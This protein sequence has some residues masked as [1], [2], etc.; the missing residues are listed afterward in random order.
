MQKQITLEQIVERDTSLLANLASV[1]VEDVKAVRTPEKLTYEVTRNIGL[2]ADSL[3]EIQKAGFKIHH[4]AAYDGCAVVTFT[5]GIM[6]CAL[7]H[8]YM[9]EVGKEVIKY[10]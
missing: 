8:D 5:R 1:P 9:C 3:E 10:A 4:V 7:R 2:Y 6:T